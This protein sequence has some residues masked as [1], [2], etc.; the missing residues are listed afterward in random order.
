MFHKTL[1]SVHESSLKAGFGTGN[2]VDKQMGDA[3]ALKA[4]LLFFVHLLFGWR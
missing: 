2:F 4:L 1:G 3:E